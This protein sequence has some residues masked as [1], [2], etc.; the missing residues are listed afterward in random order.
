MKTFP[1]EYLIVDD[2]D[3]TET[4]K[5]VN[6]QLP[7][8]W[9]KN[10]PN[11]WWHDYGLPPFRATFGGEVPLRCDI[12]YD[13]AQLK[14][15]MQTMKPVCNSTRNSYTR[16]YNDYWSWCVDKKVQPSAKSLTQVCDY[17]EVATE[18]RKVD[19]MNHVVKGV[20]FFRKLEK[21]IMEPDTDRWADLKE[22][23]R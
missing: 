17:I 20:N 9:R 21:D 8:R 18:G 11:T 2:E 16:V 22:F 13:E 7:Y 23:S 10:L 15:W 4:N 6:R 1:K 19:H 5:V 12:G 3:E 14:L